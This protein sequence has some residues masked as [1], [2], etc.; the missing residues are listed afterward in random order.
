MTRIIVCCLLIISLISCDRIIEQ[1]NEKIAEENYTSPYK[2]TWYGFYT[3]S[4]TNPTFVLEV[5]KAGNVQVTR[6]Y[7]DS[8]EEFYGQIYESGL[9][10]S[11]YSSKSGFLL[12]GSL[13]TKTGTCQQN[14]FTG[15]WTVTKK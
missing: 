7:G 10:N 14:D 8:S 6:N 5:Y 11:V 13:Q 3:G 1:Q 4:N 12:A 9:L 2:G 15:T